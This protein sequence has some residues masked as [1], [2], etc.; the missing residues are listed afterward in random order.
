MRLIYLKT[1]LINKLLIIQIRKIQIHYMN[2]VFQLLVELFRVFFLKQ[3]I[4]DFDSLPKIV[5]SK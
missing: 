2:Y 5:Q 1:I 4:V 3:E